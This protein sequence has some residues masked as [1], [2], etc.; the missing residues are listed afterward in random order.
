MA[1]TAEI[2]ERVSLTYESVSGY[3]NPKSLPDYTDFYEPCFV[4]KCGP[5]DNLLFPFLTDRKL[6]LR[7]LTLLKE[8]LPHSVYC[9]GPTTKDLALESFTFVPNGESFPA[10][11]VSL[12]LH[13]LMIGISSVST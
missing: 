8:W 2:I 5:A 13:N 12:Y 1:D 9:S 4:N 6:L 3:L 7:S 11:T 10:K